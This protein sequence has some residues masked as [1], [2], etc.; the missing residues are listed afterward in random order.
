[1]GGRG[2]LSPAAAA[3]VEEAGYDGCL[4]GYGGFVRPG[5]DSRILPRDSSPCYQNLLNLE[6]HL[7]GCLDWYYA[8]R[9]T[10]RAPESPELSMARWNSAARAESGVLTPGG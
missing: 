6:L 2:H 1:F 10:V 5:G 9:R 8:L 7:R 3:L 4:S